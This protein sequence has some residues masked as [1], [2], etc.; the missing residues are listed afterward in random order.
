MRSSIKPKPMNHDERLLDPEDFAIDAE[1][2]AVLLLAREPTEAELRIAAE[3]LRAQFRRGW[4]L[5][6]EFR[7]GRTK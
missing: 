2:L 7:S 6:G 1:R 5:R 3:A 4:I